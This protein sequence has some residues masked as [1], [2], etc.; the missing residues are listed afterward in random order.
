MPSSPSYS[1]S[2][3]PP[4]PFAP[5]LPR[6]LALR[7]ATD[8]V[9]RVNLLQD[10][11]FA[12]D[13][14][15][16]SSDVTTGAG[17]HAVG[18]SITNFPA[19][20]CQGAATTV[21][22]FKPCGM[23]ISHTHLL[24]TEILYPVNGTLTSGTIRFVFN[25]INPGQASIFPKGSVRFQANEDSEPI[26]F[27]CEYGGRIQMHDQNWR[28]L[29]AAFNLEV[30]G[31]LSVAQHYFGLPPD[32]VAAPLNNPTTQWQPRVSGNAPS[33]DTPAALVS[34]A[35]TY[36]AAS[37]GPSACATSSTAATTTPGKRD[38][39]TSLFSSASAIKHGI[40]D[41]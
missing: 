34:P 24:A 36:S 22:F 9:A 27:V 10:Q 30:P 23:N 5:M 18:A 15:N 33:P 16:S 37:S 4:A 31:T 41:F 14:F 21:G 19:L 25:T 40:Q 38:D 1:P 8:T 6:P 26:M 7:T 2:P 32:V 3:P 13:F 17:G 20:V 29:P 28:Q 11:D 35:A 12:F 39:S